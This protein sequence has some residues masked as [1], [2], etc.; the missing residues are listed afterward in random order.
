MS[1][2]G[3]VVMGCLA[4]GLPAGALA[5]SEP[6]IEGVSVSY[7]GQHDA[8]LTA[9]I[10]PKGLSARG[11]VYQFQVVTNPSEFLPEIACPI[12]ERTSRGG[13]GCVG[14]PMPGA[15]PIGSIPAGTQAREAHVELL[16]AGVGL[17]PSTTYHYRVI[18]ATSKVSED[19]L[20]WEA[21]PA[22]S[23]EGTFT[24]S[25]STTAPVV[26]ESESVSHVTSTDATL[27][28]RIDPENVKSG[29]LYQFQL[30]GNPDEYFSTFVCPP[31]W[32]GSS[33][34]LGLDT[35]AQGL[36][37]GHT[38]SGTEGQAVNLDLAH[39]GRADVSLKPGTTYHYRVIGATSK[40][41]E[42]TTQWEGPTVEGSDQT[43]TTPET[44]QPPSEVVTGPAEATSSGFK[45]EGK[46]NPDGLPTTYY[47]EYGPT[48]CDELPS[49]KQQTA[50]VGPLTG[51]AQEEVPSVEVTGINA[52]DT[53]WYR[54]VASNADGTEGGAFLTFKTSPEAHNGQVEQESESG[55][56]TPVLTPLTA[57][58][59]PI[60]IITHKALTRAQKLANALRACESKP[61][62][63]QASCKRQA[64]KKYGT[65]SNKVGKPARAHR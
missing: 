22:Y 5:A 24:T 26:I 64:R 18:A 20:E 30:V 7:V 36:P 65:I 10:N 4:L 35:E 1:L 2:A 61:K 56:L 31:E 21:P 8:G 62:K 43:F 19:T 50:V 63:R 17:K 3:L 13:G 11:A 53:Y 45:L 47:F 16:A 9:W 57:T 34:C 54:L 32:A 25:P 42:D 33:L 37:F 55:P 41:S 6:A 39:A 52:G 15:L 14:S 38:D 51:N 40:F 12:H 27:E 29:A 48:T 28:A 46:L 60:E 23:E 49:C 44:H 59:P 58:S